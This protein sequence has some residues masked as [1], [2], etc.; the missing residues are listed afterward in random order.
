MVPISVSAD[1]RPLRAGTDYSS[2]T[3]K[4]A[5]IVSPLS[6]S[7]LAPVAA[8]AA[9]AEALDHVAKYVEK[10]LARR[11][12]VSVAEACEKLELGRRTVTAAFHRL[13]EERDYVVVSAD[14]IGTVI[15]R[16]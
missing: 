7:A 14:D 6:S 5:S 11:E 3:S 12:T 15:S 10:R 13:A 16:R 9:A 8:P 4:S 2:F 1:R